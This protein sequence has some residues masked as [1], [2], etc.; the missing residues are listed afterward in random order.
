MGGD[1]GSTLAIQFEMKKEKYSYSEIH[2]KLVT[3]LLA[4]I[5]NGTDFLK[6]SSVIYILKI[7]LPQFKWIPL[8]MLKHLFPST[9]PDSLSGLRIPLL[10]NLRFPC[11]EIRVIESSRV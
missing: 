7:T 10:T 9:D 3:K 1:L 2:H 5:P 4:E 6:F 8:R 11:R